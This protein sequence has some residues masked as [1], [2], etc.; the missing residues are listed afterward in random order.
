MSVGGW[1]EGIYK[2]GIA[3]LGG[4][5]MNKEEGSGQKIRDQATAH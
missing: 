5:K 3:E 4:D 1:G 2:S